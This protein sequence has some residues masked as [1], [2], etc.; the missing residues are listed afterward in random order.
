MNVFMRTAP[1]NGRWMK[2]HAP[3]KCPTLQINQATLNH[4]AWLMNHQSIVN[5]QYQTSI[6]LFLGIRPPDLWGSPRS[7]EPLSINPPSG[8]PFHT[9]QGSGWREFKTNFLEWSNHQSSI[10]TINTQYSRYSLRQRDQP[11]P[12]ALKHP[13]KDRASNATTITHADFAQKFFSCIHHTASSR[14]I[15]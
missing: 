8:S 10:E 5:H 7:P 13:V 9:R 4:E 11:P 3:S 14:I 6:K 12:S 15:P 1:S 2:L